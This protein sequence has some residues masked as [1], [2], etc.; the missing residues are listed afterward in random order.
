MKIWSGEIRTSDRIAW[1]RG[2]FS[3]VPSFLFHMDLSPENVQFI[4]SD[5]FWANVKTKE[6]GSIR[7]GIGPGVQRY[8]IDM[9]QP[10][11]TADSSDLEI[12]REP[13]SAHPILGPPQLSAP[14]CPLYLSLGTP[15]HTNESSL[16]FIAWIDSS[17]AGTVG[18]R[19]IF[20]LLAVSNVE[21][22][23]CPGH[24]R[25][26]QFINIKTSMWAQR[27]W[28]KL[29]SRQY[30]I[31]MPARGDKCWA[32]FVAGQLVHLDGRIVFKCPTCA[33]ESYKSSMPESAQSPGQDPRGCFIGLL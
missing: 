2:I 14:D 18:I 31:F 28:D 12:Q 24:D 27:Y 7:S 10:S 3:V 26:M 13:M 22:Q 20:Y 4:C 1:R 32:L 16:C 29:Q 8:D 30:P 33:V 6:D 11:G 21:P 15:M 17:V 9:S 23:V 5:Q 19:D 25:H